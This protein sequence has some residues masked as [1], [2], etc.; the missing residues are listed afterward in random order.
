M[1][2]FGGENVRSAKHIRHGAEATQCYAA[3]LRRHIEI[4][5]AGHRVA[6]KSHQQRWA[7]NSREG[8]NQQPDLLLQLSPAQHRCVIKRHGVE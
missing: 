3:R 1:P 4:S 5:C 6:R 7:V 2:T 8:I